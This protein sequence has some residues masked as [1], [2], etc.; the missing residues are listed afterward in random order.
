GMTVAQYLLN[1][2]QLASPMTWIPLVI[3]AVVAALVLLWTKCD[4]FR[5]FWINLWENIKT[6]CSN[7]VAAIGLF[8]TE[9]LPQAIDKMVEFFAELPT[10]VQE[11]LLNTANKVAEWAADMLVKAKEL[12]TNFLNSVVQFFSELPYKLGYLLGQ[13]IAQVIQWGID[14]YKFATTKVPEFINKV[15][16]Y[17]KTLPTKV[18]DWLTKTLSNIKTWGT[19]AITS[20]KDTGKKFIDN[21]ISFVKDLPSKVA[22]W[23]STTLSKVSSWGSDLAKKGKDAAKNLFDNIVDTIKELPS[24]LLDIGSDIVEGLWNG[25]S[26]M[27]GWISSKISSFGE[28]VLGGIKD[29]FGI[30][31]PS[32][33][34][35]DEVGK[36]I[37][38]GIAVGIEK[39]AKSALNSMKDLAV[40]SVSS[41]RNGLAGGVSTAGS[42]VVN[43]FYQT[44]NSPKALSRLEIYRQS[45]NLLSYTGGA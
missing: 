25:I 27:S 37:P 12:G 34:M 17:I 35:A 19:N 38:E 45:K 44:N 42:S 4:W 41:A 24:K 1:A 29:F 26:N 11:W 31:S 30:N 16:E 14:L 10:K 15:V 40:N 28:G 43:N 7:A 5:E 20:A 2:A 13:A 22:S 21:V 39:N 36:W 6:F 32:K 33:V 8:F 9:T 18:K 3:A 23:L